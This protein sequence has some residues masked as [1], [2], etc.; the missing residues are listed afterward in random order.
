VG[1]SV[2]KSVGKAAGVTPLTGPAIRVRLLGPL[3]VLKDDVELPLPASRKVRAL[4]VFLAMATG[5]VTRSR[6][7]ELL[8]DVPNDP[9]GELRW[10]LS[11]LRGVLDDRQHRRVEARG[12]AITLNLSD[13]LVD[14]TEITRT[15]QPTLETLSLQQ[16]RAVE[17]LFVGDFAE[18]LEID[19]NPEFASWLSAQRR[20]FCAIHAAVLEKLIGQLT[21]DTDESLAYLEKW[22]QLTPFD[23][24]AHELM[25][26]ALWRAGRVQE[27]EEHLAATIRRFEAEGLEWLSI[28]EAW[29][30]T[31]DRAPDRCSSVRAYSS[32]HA[33]TEAEPSGR[34]GPGTRASICVMPFVDRTQEGTTRGGLADGLTED[35]ITRLAKLRSLFVIARG[36]VFALAERN[37]PAEEAA[38]LLNVDYVAS[39]WVRRHN[40]YV[41]VSVEVVEA[42]IARIVWVDDFTYPLDDA[43]AA[44]D[45][46]GN[47][48]VASIAE[49]IETA[50]CKRALL[51]P[52]NSLNAWE[53]YHRGL[54]HV[55]RFNGED[56]G[57]AAHF[58][59]TALLQDRTFARA[60][61]GLSFTHFQ[62]AFLLRTAERD[63]EIERAYATAAQSLSAD[64]RDPAAHWA[65]GRALWLRGSQEESLREL[66]QCVNLSPNFA[67]GHYTL[68]FVHGQSGDARLAIASTDHSLRLSP[69]DPLTFAMYAARAIALV[70]LGQYEE[71]AI[72]AMKGAARPNAHEHVL[73]IAATCLA[74]TGRVNEA[75]ELTTSLRKRQE[76]YGLDDFL[77]AFQFAGDTTALFRHN[78]ALAG[79][80]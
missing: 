42:R 80:E 49:E 22:L 46:I 8:W 11:K 69:F 29:K 21:D 76:N 33:S 12:D 55:Y 62:N 77:G 4:L 59:H 14:V 71:A 19:R 48:I 54:W 64:D 66:Q 13:C 34:T 15:A 56:N 25:L 3:T 36:S 58:F 2:V 23:S 37:I 43:L 39:G 65:M 60:Y 32:A 30:A 63:K 61:A 27:G 72:S 35:I 7:C 53:A 18:G 1:T 5:S 68:G 20:R 31:R 74:A 75:R 41:T 28:R 40:N 38:R 67:L 78:A 16:L 50:E 51:K 70:R 47:S 44:L 24:R 26:S 52:P 6:L 79:L 73:A 57:Q 17:A 10:S 45:D 9:R